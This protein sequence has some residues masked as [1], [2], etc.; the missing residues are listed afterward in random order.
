MIASGALWDVRS[1]VGAVTGDKLA[2]S[3]L[4]H[5]ARSDNDFTDLLEAVLEAD[6]RAGGHHATGIRAAFSRHGVEANTRR[7]RLGTLPWLP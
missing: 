5:L 1:Q 2:L 7:S 6:R 3:A 4:A